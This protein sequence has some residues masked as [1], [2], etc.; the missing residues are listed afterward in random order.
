MKR[1]VHAVLRAGDAE[2]RQP[3]LP[4][5]LNCLVWTDLAVVFSEVEIESLTPTVPGLEAFARTVAELHR[6]QATIPFRFGCTVESDADLLRL[7]RD[8]RDGWI[9]MLD[10]VDQCDEYTVHLTANAGSPTHGEQPAQPS[11]LS[12]VSEPA[13]RPGT[14]YLLARRTALQQ[15]SALHKEALERAELVRCS[16]QGLYRSYQINTPVPGSDALI[17]L[18]FLV[19]RV[20]SA[21][22][23]SALAAASRGASNRLITT[24]PWPP[25]HFTAPLAGVDSP[26]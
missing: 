14:S 26:A 17:S 25:Y 11:R 22:F 12:H 2:G 8:H 6:A 13:D 10:H 9:A 24:G 3:V 7:L 19:P 15:A 5:G 20:S 1:L 23:L 18:V 4:A 21:T 16:L